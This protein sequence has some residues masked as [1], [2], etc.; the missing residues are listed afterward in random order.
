MKGKV[1]VSRVE[2]LKVIQKATEML[3][4]LEDYLEMM[5]SREAEFVE[6]LRSQIEEDGELSQKQYNW[7]INIHDNY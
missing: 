3:E 7:L 2:D 6:S 4:Y 1:K 5:S